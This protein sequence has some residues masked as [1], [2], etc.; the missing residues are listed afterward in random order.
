MIGIVPAAGYATRL[1]GLDGSKEML[2][3]GGAPVI[4]SLVARLEV[5]GCTEIR[6]VTRPEKGDV[7]EY[8]VARGLRVM[9]GYPEHLG[10]SI[11]I[12][13]DGVDGPVALGFPDSLW[14]PLDGF[15]LLREAMRTDTDVVLG[16]F[17]F[18]DPQRADVVSTDTDGRVREIVVKPN[19]PP[20][21]V[22]W[23]CF[24][25][26]AAALRGVERTPWPSD[27]LRPLIEEGRVAGRFL[28]DR[29]VDI[30][31]PDGLATA[32]RQRWIVGSAVRAPRSV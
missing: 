14:E 7:R 15:A 29:Y 3:I 30:G 20:S 11:G 32:G 12:G 10:Q 2:E 9:L 6:V 8:A 18:D 28:S 4:E 13:L 26:E 31:T 23:G 17:E 5:G 27:H 19:R 25:G 21:N 16:L 1:G 22:I 24:V